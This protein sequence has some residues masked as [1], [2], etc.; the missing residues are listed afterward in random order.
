MFEALYI[1]RQRSFRNDEDC[2]SLREAE[3][4]LE[5]GGMD[6]KMALVVSS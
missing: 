4:L 2:T 6:G 1:R 3:M 5:Q